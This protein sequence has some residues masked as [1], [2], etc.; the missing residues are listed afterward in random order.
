MRLLPEKISKFAES[1][2]GYHHKPGRRGRILVAE[3]AACVQRATD[4]IAGNLNLDME[5]AEDGRIA[6]EMA[7]RS[8]TEGRPYD[9]ILM[10]M[11][12]PNM[13]GIEATQWLRRNDWDG[14][15]VAVS[16]YVDNDNR[17]LFLDS[18]CDEFIA[19]PL[20]SKKLRTTLSR[21]AR[22]Y[23]DLAEILPME[24]DAEATEEE[25]PALRGRL[26]VAE[27]ARCIQMVVRTL[28]RK[29]SLEADMA[30]NGKISC[31]MAV[32]SQTEGHPY[33]VIL[34]DM[35]M[36]KM[37]G[38]EAAKWLRDNGWQGTIIAVSIHATEEDHQAFLKAGCDDY[39]T[40]PVTETSLREVLSEYLPRA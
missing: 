40:K 16:I 30:D 35:Q 12:M 6:C 9:L 31:E 23:H 36:P 8:K 2:I 15:I 28:L 25:K 26:L 10:D 4:M 20:T 18:G 19:K 17:Q 27:D 38:K 34:M 22:Q 33:D 32:K 5:I 11:Q 3:D 1:V 29:M 39:V 14:P 13:D 37:N 7:Q 21:L 24:H